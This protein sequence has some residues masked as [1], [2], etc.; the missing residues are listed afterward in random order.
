MWKGLTQIRNSWVQISIE[1]RILYKS[2]ILQ[3]TRH[4]GWITVI[5]L[6]FKW[7]A[8][9]DFPDKW[10]NSA[11]QK[12]SKLKM[13]TFM[14]KNLILWWMILNQMCF[15]CK[16]Q[17]LWNLISMN[18]LSKNKEELME[19]IILMMKMMIKTEMRKMI[20]AIIVMMAMKLT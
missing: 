16:K 4:L 14:M 17:I 12:S 18:C 6:Q 7:A 15:I 19:G 10:V 1:S 11:I 2:K 8:N 5:L 13:M 20:I 9:Q 3:H